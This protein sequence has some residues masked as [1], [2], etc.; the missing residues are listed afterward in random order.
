M[1]QSTF[2]ATALSPLAFAL[3][4]GAYAQ[5]PLSEGIPPALYAE[6]ETQS[7]ADLLAEMIR[8]H[9]DTLSTAQALLDDG[10]APDAIAL[11]TAIIAGEAREIARLERLLA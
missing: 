9:R 6:S 3:A 10:S 2:R 7:Q 1:V 4:F 11:A 5:S 8:Q